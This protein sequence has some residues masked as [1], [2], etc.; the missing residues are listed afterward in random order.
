[1]YQNLL[2]LSPVKVK[3]FGGIWMIYQACE[4]CKNEK[5]KTINGDD[6]LFSM[7]TLGFDNYFDICH[8]YL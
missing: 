4:K 8:T 5:R 6:I 3:F 1:M 2:V 7:N